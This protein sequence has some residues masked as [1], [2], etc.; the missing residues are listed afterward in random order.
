[1]ENKKNLKRIEFVGKAGESYFN[2][3]FVPSTE[4]LKE[5]AQYQKR[6]KF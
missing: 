5:L 6:I 1:M 3:S 2:S 4:Q